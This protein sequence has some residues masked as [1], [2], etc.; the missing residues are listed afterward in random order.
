ME[1]LIIQP[2]RQPTATFVA[3]AVGYQVGAPSTSGGFSFQEQNRQQYYDSTHLQTIMFQVSRLIVD[4]L[5]AYDRSGSDKRRRVLRLQ[6]RHQLFP[7]VFRY[8]EEYVRKKVGFQGQHPCELGL[9]EYV[10][11]LVERLR[12][13]IVPDDTEG[14]PPL[15]PLLNRYK[16]IGTTADVD[17]KTTRPCFATNASHI[18]QVVT[19][20]KTWETSAAFRIEQAVQQGVAKFYARNDSMGLVIPY[21]Y[22]GVDHS[23]EPDFLVRLNARAV[24][25]PSSWKSKALRMTRPRR[26]TRRLDVGCR[27]STTGASLASGLS[28]S[29]GT[30][31]LSTRSWPICCAKPVSERH[32]G[33]PC[34]SC[35]TD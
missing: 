3:A 35:P 29:A 19:D 14:E 34:R 15:L 23:Y 2:N 27:Q 9:Q 1:R 17:F 12:D 33:G 5:V 24:I 21:E 22:V 28:M 10:E 6:S 7:Q 26:S 16:P 11:R 25:S 32:D 30:P 31:R 18:N 8:V 20:T 13:G 4:D